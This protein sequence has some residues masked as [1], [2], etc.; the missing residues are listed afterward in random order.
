MNAPIDFQKFR[1]GIGYGKA[2]RLPCRID[3]RTRKGKR[4][5]ELIER[6]AQE[7]GGY[8]SLPASG[9]AVARR[10][11]LETYDVENPPPGSD[12]TRFRNAQRRSLAELQTYAPKPQTTHSLNVH[13]AQAYG[14]GA[15]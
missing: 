8:E 3:G 14:S 6:F 2:R 12:P 7:V 10:L 5:G 1:T 11:A 15:K 4:I 13:L 9:Q